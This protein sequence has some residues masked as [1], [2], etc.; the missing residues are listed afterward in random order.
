[1]SFVACRFIIYYLYTQPPYGVALE[2]IIDQ[3]FTHMRLSLLAQYR[4]MTLIQLQ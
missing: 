2:I 1:M 3:A 4:S